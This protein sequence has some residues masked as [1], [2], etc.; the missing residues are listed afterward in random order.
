MGMKKGKLLEI[1]DGDNNIIGTDD[2]P[3]VSPNNDTEA[4]GTTDHNAK[5]GH[6]D[7]NNDYLGKFGYYFFENE[8]SDTLKTKIAKE[9]YNFFDSD[10]ELTHEP[11]E[12]FPEEKKSHYLAFAEKVIAL[13]EQKAE[14]TLSEVE[15]RK[16]AED[17]IAKRKDRSFA[18]K[19]D[20]NDIVD[21]SKKIKDL[22]RD[23]TKDE[24]TKLL[25]T[26]ESC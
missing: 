7:F 22:F 18:K 14:K 25:K 20:D 24:K 5:M 3:Q 9:A 26:L 12:Q 11:F 2:K 15:L 23:L 4:Q 8:G 16:I 1:L 10:S 17:V 19:K 21:K 6:Q 13:F